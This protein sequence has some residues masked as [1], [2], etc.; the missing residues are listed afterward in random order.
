MATYLEIK[1]LL[2]EILCI[3][4]DADENSDIL[5][6]S[7][8]PSHFV[9]ENTVLKAAYNNMQA[10]SKDRLE[11]SATSYREVA[12]QFSS[13]L[14]RFGPEEE[15]ITDSTNGLT[16]SIG[17]ASLD[18]CMFL[19]DTVAE[20]AKVYGRRIYIDLRHRSRMVLSRGMQ[21]DDADNPLGL[22]PEIL[23]AYT[24]KINSKKPTSLPRLRECAASFEFLLMYKQNVAVSEYTDVQDMYL[25]GR[26][27]LRHHREEFD[28]PPQRIFN[29]EVLD[30]YTMAMESRDPF[31]MYI[32][33]YH[34]V[35]FYFDAVYR[36]KLTEEIKNKLTHPDFSYKNETKIYEL[37]K[38]IKKH[39]SSDDV[40]GRGNEFE[41]LKFVLIEYVPIEELKKRIDDLDSNAVS[42]YRNNLVPFTISQKTKIAWTDAQ[43]VYTNL[44]TRIYETRNALVHS[45]SEQTASQYRPYEDRR[46]LLLE[47]A[48]IRSVAELV[49]IKSSKIM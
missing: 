28:T 3:N 9:L 12:L 36:K 35:E 18:Y 33:F 20:A 4:V 31:T 14:W 39:M 27:T 37:A 29:A 17:L 42:Y 5:L 1:Q 11:L 8:A 34:V 25:L 26:S 6:Y 7:N 22:L 30:Y 24:L 43:G 19:L 47:I 21:S 13:P 49:I 16:Y 23:K 46:D 2:N 44:A 10:Y 45:K 32:S 48:L 41:S 40:S 38:Y 15:E